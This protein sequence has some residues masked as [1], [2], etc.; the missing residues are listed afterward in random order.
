MKTTLFVQ[1]ADAHGGID[2]I[3][4]HVKKRQREHETDDEIE[5]IDDGETKIKS[6]TKSKQRK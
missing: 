3:R 5:E 6:K 2:D 4:R 1:R